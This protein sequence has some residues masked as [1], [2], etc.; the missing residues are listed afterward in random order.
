MYNAGKQLV[1]LVRVSGRGERIG[2][3][4]MRYDVR[5]RLR[6]SDDRNVIVTLLRW[7]FPQ[8]NFSRVKILLTSFTD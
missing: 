4:R 6:E 2:V 3:T 5:S 1:L 7:N 8:A